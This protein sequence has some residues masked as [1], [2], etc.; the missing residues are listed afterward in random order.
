METP[1]KAIYP[2]G[3]AFFKPRDGAPEWVKG[4]I[5]ISVKDFFDWANENADLLVAN[6]KYGKQLKLTLTDKGVQV[7]TWKPAGA[8]ANVAPATWGGDD[9]PQDWI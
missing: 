9:K 7:D 8:S 4:S 6:E 1:K 5:I 3:V 2:K